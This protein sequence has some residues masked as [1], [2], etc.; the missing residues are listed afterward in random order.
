MS[1]TKRQGSRV[2]AYLS[3]IACLAW[4]FVCALQA[5][6]GPDWDGTWSRVPAAVG[7]LLVAGFAYR[8]DDSLL[9]GAAGGL[10]FMLWCWG[11]AAALP[12]GLNQV[13]KR[14]AAAHSPRPGGG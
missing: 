1:G 8:A 5:A 11:L 13:H 6:L 10:F 2:L 14:A 12:S 4:F 7:V 3:G 9:E